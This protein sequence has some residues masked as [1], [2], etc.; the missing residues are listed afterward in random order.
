MLSQRKP[1]KWSKA[2]QEWFD[3]YGV[4]QPEIKKWM[5]FGFTVRE[6]IAWRDFNV[7]PLKALK[8]VL[9]GRIT[10]PDPKFIEEDTSISVAIS[11]HDAGFNED[12]SF[13]WRQWNI[14]PTKAKAFVESGLVNPPDFDTFEETGITFSKALSWLNHGFVDW[15]E[16][17]QV[18]YY[19]HEWFLAGLTPSKAKRVRDELIA[20]VEVEFSNGTKPRKK[21]FSLI[22]ERNEYPDKVKMLDLL[23]EVIEALPELSK[24][25]IAI[26]AENLIRW[27]GLKSEEILE[28]IDHGVQPDDADFG[29]KHDVRPDQLELLEKIR[30]VEDILMDWTYARFLLN[31]GITE[32]QLNYLVKK[33][34]RLTRIAE[35]IRIHSLTFNT[36]IKWAKAGWPVDVLEKDKFGYQ[37]S[38]LGPWIDTKLDPATAYRWQTYNFTADAA[39]KWINAGVSDPEIANRRKVA[40]IEPKS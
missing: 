29:R 2:D 34:F 27:R 15:A 39:E 21:P 26:T 33:G 5:E 3:P 1:K 7:M 14:S 13:P 10:P 18:A 31:A 4:W 23:T 24:T 16:K 30:A 37:Q 25:H 36:I 8:F 35:A 12:T 28:A 40:G 6:A 20:R 32:K 38:V 22:F 9:G 11:W 17:D 19:Y